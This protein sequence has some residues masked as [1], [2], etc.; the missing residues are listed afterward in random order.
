MTSISAQ[1]GFVIHLSVPPSNIYQM[2]DPC[3]GIVDTK[4]NLRHGLSSLGAF[5]VLEKTD[6]EEGYNACE[7]F[8]LGGNNGCQVHLRKSYLHTAG[9]KGRTSKLLS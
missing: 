2:P 1:S 5:Y 7:G 4:M 3:L 9:E 6:V 8:K